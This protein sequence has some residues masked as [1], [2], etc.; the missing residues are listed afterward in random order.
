M[1]EYYKDRQISERKLLL[2][3]LNQKYNTNLTTTYIP[4]IFT[5]NFNK[6]FRKIIDDF[7]PKQ[8]SEA[9]LFVRF[10]FGIQ[11]SRRDTGSFYQT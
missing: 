9:I 7:G 11:T 4:S 6:K 3:Y 5:G 10:K 8:E 1:E 2:N